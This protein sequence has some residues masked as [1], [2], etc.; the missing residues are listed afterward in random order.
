MACC[1]LEC[2]SAGAN[3][4]PGKNPKF[5]QNSNPRTPNKMVGPGKALNGHRIN[6][7][8]TPI[9]GTAAFH[10]SAAPKKEADKAIAETP[11]IEK[12][13]LTCTLLGD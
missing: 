13:D 5:A 10:P 3:Q 2:H 4:L 11:T 1:S 8:P 12:V 6:S 7:N 9:T